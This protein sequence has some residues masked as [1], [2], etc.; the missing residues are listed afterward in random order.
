[1][2]ALG[3]SDDALAAHRKSVLLSQLQDDDASQLQHAEASSPR[4]SRASVA[5]A[6]QLEAIALLLQVLSHVIE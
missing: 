2:W 5:C 6:R 3:G 1:L 4:G